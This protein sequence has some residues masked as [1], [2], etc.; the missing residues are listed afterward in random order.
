MSSVGGHDL[1]HELTDWSWGWGLGLLG[2]LNVLWVS[3]WHGGGVSGVWGKWLDGVSWVPSSS[4]VWGWG[5]GVIN[6]V[7]VVVWWGW[8]VSDSGLGSGDIT[9]GGVWSS[10]N[11]VGVV[12]WDGGDLLLDAWG[13]GW[14]IL[15]SV[16]SIAGWGVTV[17]TERTVV[18]VAV[19]K[20]RD[21]CESKSSDEFHYFY[22]YKANFIE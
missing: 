9:G 5:H 13:T 7:V 8:V 6:V 14:A 11:W 4:G 16:G 18:S 12:M 17:D 15:W 10:G 21:G 2:E 19:W 20:G 3:S 1:S 22:N